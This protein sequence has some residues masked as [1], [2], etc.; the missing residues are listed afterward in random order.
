MARVSLFYDSEL[1]EQVFKVRGDEGYV[2]STSTVLEYVSV[3][4]QNT[5][6]DLTLSVNVFRDVGTGSIIIYDGDE[7]YLTISDWSSQDNARTI[8]LNNLQY[9]TDYN[10]RAEYIGNGQSQRSSSKILYINRP[11]THLTTPTLTLTSDTQ[12]DT[13]DEAEIT[14]TID[15]T[16]SSSYNVGQEVNIYYDDV[17]VNSYTTQSNG[18]ITFTLANVGTDGLHTITAIYD[19]S[20]HLSSKTTSK[21]ISVG[22]QINVIEYPEKYTYDPDGTNLH[23]YDYAVQLLNYLDMPL[24][25]QTLLLQTYKSSQWQPQTAFT[26]GSDGISRKKWYGRDTPLR[27]EFGNYVSEEFS[28]EKVTPTGISLSSSTSVLTKNTATDVTVQ[29]TPA[30]EGIQ[31]DLTGT[32]TQSAKTNSRGEVLFNYEGNGYGGS[33][34]PK[35]FNAQ[36]YGTTKTTSISIPDYL[37]YWSPNYIMNRDYQLVYGVMNDLTTNFRITPQN[38]AVALVVPPRTDD[39]SLK[40]SGISTSATGNMLLGYYDDNVFT[41]VASKENIK[42]SNHSIIFKKIDSQ[43]DCTLQQGNTTVAHGLS[44]LGNNPL[45]MF[46]GMGNVQFNKLELWEL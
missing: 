38:N 9:D 19:G 21:N 17:F 7:V 46:S 37:Q 31:I 16:I 45:M 39:F 10:F 2:R 42:L 15:N 30:T 3:S 18:E 29:M 35:S 11:D 5:Y 26:T 8:V 12:F 28:S 25:R 41:G 23:Q 22:Y 13:N 27:F 4:E 44:Y 6:F 33:E 24:S 20:E 43:L 34:I 36:I 40:V 14:I 32:V 1:N